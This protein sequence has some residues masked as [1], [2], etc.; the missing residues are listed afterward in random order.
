VA[1]NKLGEDLFYRLILAEE[2]VGVD[3]L[4]LGVTGSVPASSV[5]MRVA[6]PIAEV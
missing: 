4:P 5:M 2:D 3:P 1:A 6:V